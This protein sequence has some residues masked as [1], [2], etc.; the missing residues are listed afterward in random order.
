MADRYWVGG[1]GNWDSFN[2]TNWSATTG[3]AGGASVPTS[4]DNVIFDANS[5]ASNFLVTVGFGATCANLTISIAT[6]GRLT[7]EGN[8]NSQPIYAYGAV[9]I[10]AATSISTSSPISLSC[11]ATSGSHTITTNNVRFAAVYFGETASTATWTL[12]SGLTTQYLAML[13]AGTTLNTNGQTVTVTTQYYSGSACAFN[14]Q[15]AATL[16]LGASAINIGTSASEWFGSVAYFQLVGAGGLATINAN[17][18][19]IT[20]GSTSTVNVNDSVFSGGGKT[21][22]T[23]VMNGDKSLISGTN[24]FATRFA[25]NGLFNNSYLWVEDNQT[26][27]SGHTFQLIGT[28]T[29]RLL[30]MSSVSRTQRTFTLL[31]TT[32]TRTLSFVN[33]M[34]IALSFGSAVSGT[35]LGDMLGNSGI[36]FPAP[37]T[38]YL[39]LGTATLNFTDTNAWSANPSGIPTG[40]S[41]PLPQDTIILNATSGTGTLLLDISYL[42]SI[43]T[44][45]FVGNVTYTAV[46]ELYCVGQQ[47]DTINLIRNTNVDVI[48]RF[49]SNITLPAFP[50]NTT[51][52][53][54]IDGGSA[55]ANLSANTTVGF[56]TNLSGNFATSNFNL[57]AI[58][59]SSYYAN[60]FSNY[61][62]IPSSSLLSRTL[63]LGSS[64]VT[65]TSNFPLNLDLTTL[66]AGTSTIEV[67]NTS[68]TGTSF[69]AASG[70]TFNNLK[71]TESS[72]NVTFDYDGL[73]GATFNNLTLSSHTNLVRIRLSSSTTTTVNS[74]SLSAAKG[75]GVIIGADIQFVGAAFGNA[76][77]AIG[78]NI[79]TEYVAYLGITK[80]G[81]SGLS[82]RGAADL[83]AN[84]GITFEP[85][86]VIAF[87][88]SGATSFTVPGNFTGSSYFLVLGAGGGGGKRNASILAAGGGG[89]GSC[90]VATN[91][92]VS[93]GQTIFLNAPT[94]G[95]GATVS[96]A[97]GSPANAWVNIAANS[98][99]TLITNGAFASSGGGSPGVN[100]GSGGSGASVSATLGQ[101][102]YGGGIGGT[103]SGPGGGGGGSPA[104][105]IFRTG[106]NGAQSSS[107]GAGGGGASFQNGGLQSAVTNTGGDGGAVTPNA[108]GIG[109]VGG[110]PPAAGGNG[111]AGTSVGG[112]GGGNSTAAGVNSGI[113]GNGATGGQWTYNRLNGVASTGVIGYG[114][115]GGGGGGINVTSNANSAG[116]R[117][118]NGGNGAGGAGG[119]RGSTSGG[120]TGNGGNGGDAL[121]LFVYVEARGTGFATIIG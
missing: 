99:P 48:Y 107:I 96:G 19:V 108:G 120:A 12:G 6:A 2:P 29:A 36:S 14:I 41:V 81:A 70:Q 82:A 39:I 11:A 100:S 47:T 53:L 111:A 67:V 75:A 21:Y 16:T 118:G 49:N 84:I 89:G 95:A 98:Q 92:N 46:D 38:R 110:N 26:L 74:M 76:T 68:G 66:N 22:A 102:R 65:L 87:S 24:T 3:G 115:A 72:S 50:C 32:G 60:S 93:T 88:G 79:V 33:F 31:G 101:L 54:Y 18:S 57:N 64:Y 104:S 1:T 90:V 85:H 73:S 94:G 44:T 27:N 23:V 13:V 113:G 77:L 34:D 43:N 58:G 28:A 37:T 63:S 52:N 40:A 35:S 105:L 78:S 17:T 121:V 9:S 20:I 71:L 30:V 8:P 10:N 97:G 45:G 117:G 114:G 112:G 51:K 25:K 103:T 109:G 106:K 86:S 56:I 55:T 119:G 61:V 15:E 69:T 62:P 7:F 80:S 59:I 4:A 116:G 5:G 83:G 91:L 42:G